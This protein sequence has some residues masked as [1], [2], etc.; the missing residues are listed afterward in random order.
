L[1]IFK[2]LKAIPISWY[3]ERLFNSNNFLFK[4]FKKQLNSSIKYFVQCNHDYRYRTLVNTCAYKYVYLDGYFQSEQYFKN[5]R[6]QLLTEF[7][8]PELDEKNKRIKERIKNCTNAISVHIRRGDY[9]KP[10]FADL[11]GLL[12][13]TYY[14]NAFKSLN[15]K[16]EDKTLFVFS[17]D[18][19]WAKE[20]F[21]AGNA[22]IHFVENKK[23]NAWKDM[24]LMS[25]CR[26]HIIA[27]S[28]FSWWGAWLSNRKGEVFAPYKW[29]NPE[30][31]KF[32]I[33]DLIP[34]DWTIVKYE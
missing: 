6:E 15:K 1:G 31:V 11:I 14:N 34:A 24:L 22:D 29:F 27:N 25:A 2:N 32:N 12:P 13:S 10:I 5:I 9:L 20:N 26:H 23:E 28:S 30:K 21:R 4:A 17:D 7:E 8:F 19:N 3:H 33:S 18:I 16:M